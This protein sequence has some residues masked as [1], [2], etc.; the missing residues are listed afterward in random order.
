MKFRQFDQTYLVRLDKD[1][2]VIQTLKD[3]AK[4]NHITLASLQG[5]GA[6]N[7]IKVSL[8]EVENKIYQ[9]K[10]FLGDFEIAPLLGNITTMK[11]ETYL[12]IHINFS[13]K[14][15]NSFGGH[16]NEAYISATCE[17]VINCWEG[18]VDR[19]FSQEI[20]LNLLKF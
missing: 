6:A 4:D 12:H 8:F 9:S 16:L 14:N 15:F 20:G 5:I 7:K 18:E 1:E 3:F 11:G 2:E 13:D 17:I 10:E 19:K